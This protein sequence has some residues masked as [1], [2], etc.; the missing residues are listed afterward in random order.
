MSILLE[1]FKSVKVGEPQVFKNLAIFPLVLAEQKEPDYLLLDEALAQGVLEVRELS[2]EG[3][4]NKILVCN[5]G[6]HPVLILDGE[7]LAGAKQNRVINASTLVGPRSELVVPVSCVEQRRW[8]YVSEK[9]TES[10]HFSYARMRAQKSVQVAQCLM[11]AGGF[12]A[13]QGAIWNE[14]DRKQ[15]EMGVKSATGAVNEVYENH[16]EELTEYCRAFQPLEG[17]SGVAVFINGYF[18]CLDAFDSQAS[19][20]KLFS[21][22]VESYALDALEQAGKE[23]KEVAQSA[24]EAI[25]DQAA[26]T[27]LSHYPSTGIGEDLRFS[28]RRLIGS[29]LAADGKVIHLALFARPEEGSRRPVNPLSRPSSRRK[30]YM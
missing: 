6:E 16:G 19:L 28:A 5:R 12:A 24:V 23:S 21:K 29:C 11:S 1:F 20:R 2:A 25:I 7:V 8:Q 30:S 4:V 15:R 14:V 13:D 27:K 3:S 18:I 9:F 17:Q 26:A 22:M 10:R